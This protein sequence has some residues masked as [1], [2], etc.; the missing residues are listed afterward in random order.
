MVA[1]R[2]SSIGTGRSRQ[3]AIKAARMVLTEAG[4]LNDSKRGFFN[5]CFLRIGDGDYGLFNHEYA[6]H[7]LVVPKD[8]F[9]SKPAAS[10]AS[11]IG[12]FGPNWS[13]STACS[14][15]AYGIAIACDAIRE[16]FVDV[17]IVSGAEAYSILP[18][19]CFHQM[20]RD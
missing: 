18:V 7:D 19:A 9:Y 16:G 1:S 4:F 20:K 5:G 6:G 10:V 15:S 14:A 8:T 11:V 3:F 13:T 17:M 2:R 12:A